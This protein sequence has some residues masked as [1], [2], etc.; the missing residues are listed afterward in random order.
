M[1]PGPN[2]I[3]YKVYKN[4]PKL[5]KRMWKMFRII[6]RRGE[7][8][9]SWRRVEGCFIPKEENSTTISQFRTISLLNVEEKIF[10]AI[11]A[12]RVTSFLLKNKY[13]DT[14]VQKGGVPGVPG[15][16]EHATMITEII[17]EAKKNCGDL[18]VI[19]LDLPNAYGTI[20][21]KLIEKM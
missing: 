10:L 4:C 21:H 17:K 14:S 1:A 16:I 3:P 2:G 7:L 12:R 5:V 6:W 15:C 13:I 18:V 8:A 19:W 20:P 11:L 9:E